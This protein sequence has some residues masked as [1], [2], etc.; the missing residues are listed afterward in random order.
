MAQQRRGNRGG[1]GEDNQ[2]IHKFVLGTKELEDKTAE[3]QYDKGWYNITD[4]VGEERTVIYHSKN[5]AE[6]YAKWNVYIGRKKER[7][8]PEERKK[9]REEQKERVAQ[10]EAARAAKSANNNR[11][12]STNNN[13]NSN[14]A[15]NAKGGK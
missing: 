4:I 1:K 8:S 14:N 13:A 3:F 5:M 10:A 2:V 6:A 15:S 7:L 11:G 9:Q 12:G